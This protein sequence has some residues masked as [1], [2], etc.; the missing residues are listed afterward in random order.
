MG[1]S[2]VLL[3]GAALVF[4]NPFHAKGVASTTMA[5]TGAALRDRPPR[6]YA[7]LQSNHQKPQIASQTKA[8]FPAQSVRMSPEDALAVAEQFYEA[9]EYGSAEDI[10]REL[11]KADGQEIDKTQIAFL[12]GMIAV[13]REAYSRAEEIFRAILD[14]RPE[15]IRVRLELA[16]VL[17]AQKRDQAAAYHFRLA[18]SA[19][20]PEETIQNIRLF[21]NLIEQRRSWRINAQIG[22]APDSNISAGPKDQTVELFGLPFELDDDARERSG[23]GLSSSLSAEVYPRINDHWRLE[24]RG[25]GS[26]SDYENIQFDD[27]FLFAEGGPRLQKPDMSVSLL[28]SYSRRFFGGA[29]YSHSAGGKVAFSKGLTS[30]TRLNIR[31]SGARARYDRDSRRNGPVYSL[32]VTGV[33]IVDRV[34][35]LQSSITVTREQSSDQALRNT[36]YVLN[37]SYRREFPLG[38]TAQFGPDVYYR[39]FDN[40]TP[41]DAVV[42]RDL[43]IGGSIFL[44]KRDWRIGGFAPVIS[45]QYLHNQSNADRFDYSR[46]RANVGLTRTF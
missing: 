13:Q 31:F 8:A 42:R 24:L 16:R 26:I 30:R 15:T 37:G 40:F 28:G 1:R 6:Q 34:S 32:G 39:L 22:V 23:L 41:I 9:G 33:Q 25:G 20:L 4:A 14:E 19:E 38:V 29:G 5:F 11:T 46:H 12:L 18:L 27:I 2:L 17:F 3:I 45:Y 44:T 43:T 35:T 21:L 10:L 36:Q 7:A